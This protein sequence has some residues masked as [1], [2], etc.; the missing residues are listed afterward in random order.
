MVCGKKMARVAR[1]KTT[2]AT[3]ATTAQGGG[4]GDANSPIVLL[5]AQAEA[6]LEQQRQAAVAKA[7]KEDEALKKKARAERKDGN[8]VPCK[9]Q[10]VLP[11][12][13]YGYALE[14]GGHRYQHCPHCGQFHTYSDAG[15]GRGGY[16]CPACRAKENKLDKLERCAFCGGADRGHQ[17]KTIDILAPNQVDPTNPLHDPVAYPLQCY[18]TLHFCQK[19]SNSLGLFAKHAGER[20]HANLPKEKLWEMI[21]PANVARM[22]QQDKKHH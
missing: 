14:F 20:Y 18:Q 19:D 21:A 13:L 3:T 7:K 15:W 1:A 4:G 8:S 5:D 6:L 22:K 11:V 17:L 16:R 12:S 10:P 9:G 2:A